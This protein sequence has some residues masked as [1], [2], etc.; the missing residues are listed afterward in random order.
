VVDLRTGLLREH[1]AADYM[2]MIT[3]VGPRGDCQKWKAFLCKITNGDA[4]L[5][6]YLQRVTGYSLPGDTGEQAMFFA[7][8]VGANGKGVFLQT[9]GRILGDY[10]KTAAIET[11][12]ESKSDR[13]P[14][15]LARLHS[16]RLV[17][18]TETESG[19]NWAESRIKMLTG[20]DT[21]TAHFMRQDDFEYVPKFKLFFSGN[22]KP[23]L[24]SV[25]EAMRRRMHMIP[26]AVIIPKDE[27]DPHFVDK[28][29]DEWPGILQWMIDGCLHWHEHGLA[30][31]EAVAKETDA[32]FE[33]QDS[34]SLWIEECC[35]RDPN[36]WT[37][38][39]V[40]FG[41]WKV[42]AEKAGV[43]YGDIKSFGEAMEAAK[44]VWKR[45]KACN[46]Y[47]GLRIALEPPPQHW[48]DDRE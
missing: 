32:Y 31:P 12:T 21:V 3:P 34:F 22:H 16:A 44:F 28:L 33:A 1:R 23:G 39:T 17:T 19:R 29:K 40:L 46:G 7:Y 42:W 35:E 36:A 13:H 2:T 4:A 20:G 37:S 11:F 26:F 41:S 48:Q 24:R 27:R 15:E 38:T 9:I 45:T 6:A 5:I 10:C 43:R 25:G 47:E 30:P 18:A 14:T 8:G